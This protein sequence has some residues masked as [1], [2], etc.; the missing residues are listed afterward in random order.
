[1]IIYNNKNFC[2]KTFNKMM[3]KNLSNKVKRITNLKMIM[4]IKR[5]KIN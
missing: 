4:K 5:N 1:M 2:I 3:T